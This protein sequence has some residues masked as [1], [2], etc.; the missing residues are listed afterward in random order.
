MTVHNS[1]R[2]ARRRDAGRSAPPRARPPRAMREAERRRQDQG[3]DA[4]PPPPSAPRA[5]RSSPPT[6]DDVAAA[7]AAGMAASDAGPADAERRAHR[8][9][10]QGRRRRSPRCPI[11]SA[12]SWRA[13]RGPTGCDIARVAMP[14]GVIGIIYEIRPNVT[15][16]AGA[17]CLKSGN[18]AILRGGSES[19][20]SS[21]AIHAALRRRPRTRPACR[22]PRSSSCRR[23]TA[24][25]SA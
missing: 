9:D 1:A 5:P 17:L 12:A 23:P 16:D 25:P 10:G 19:F 11:R 14:I 4:W 8:G 3:A 13:G 20:H 6:R 21:R 2:R 15:A 22:K 7:K 24:P 18:V